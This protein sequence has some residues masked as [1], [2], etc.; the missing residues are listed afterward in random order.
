MFT[1]YTAKPITRMAVM[2][3]GP[4][5]YLDVN[6]YSYRGATFKAYETPVIGDYVVRLT[7]ADTYHCSRAVFHER[8]II[9]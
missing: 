1:P 7:E 5:E 3:T 4:C 6:T 9:P 2:I 8:N